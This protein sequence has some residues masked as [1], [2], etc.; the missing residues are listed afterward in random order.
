M[1]GKA[2]S[3]SGPCG[4]YGPARMGELREKGRGWS[5]DMCAL[6]DSSVPSFLLRLLSFVY[7]PSPSTPFS[8]PLPFL[9]ATLSPPPI[10]P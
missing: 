10:A 9:L 5:A 6:C 8:F 4:S 3:G 1:R 2:V 7:A